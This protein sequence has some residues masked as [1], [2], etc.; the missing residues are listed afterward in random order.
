MV[1]AGLHRVTWNGEW[2]RRLVGGEGSLL[3]FAVV[4][5]SARAAAGALPTNRLNDP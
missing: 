3:A 4:R 1:A 2:A 5:S